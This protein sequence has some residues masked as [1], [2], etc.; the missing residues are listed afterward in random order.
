MNYCFECG[1]KLVPKECEGEGIIPFCSCCNIFRFPI[2]NTAISTEIVCPQ[3]DKILLI[4]Q[5]GKKEYILLAG[6]INKG[7]C[8]EDAVV[9]EVKEE[10]G[11][12]IIKCQFVKSEYYAGSNTLML[13]FVSFASSADL[14]HI[15]KE[16]DLANWFSFEDARKNIKTNSL[17]EKFLLTFLNNTTSFLSI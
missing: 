2:Y 14:S 5:Y 3:K 4:Q 8:A 7:E 17:A 11:L 10:V 1:T 13:N 6:Y 9:R 16:V 15:T 12:D